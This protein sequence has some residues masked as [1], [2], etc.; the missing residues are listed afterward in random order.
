M[1]AVMIGNLIDNA[2]RHTPAGG[3]VDVGI[4]REGDHVTLLVEDT[5]PGIPQTDLARIFEP[6]FRGS[7]PDDDGTGLGLS[8]VKRI[9]ERLGGS[10]FLE[11]VVSQDRSGLRASVK[12]PA[13]DDG[14]GLKLSR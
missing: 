4:C 1:L 5:G 13:V 14:A 9:A 10:V 7:Q 12:I 3:R 6:F 2:I 11:N 8:I